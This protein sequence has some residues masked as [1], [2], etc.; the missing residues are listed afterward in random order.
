MTFI[1]KLK[2][3]GLRIL[4]FA[5]A[6][7]RRKKLTLVDKANVLETSRLWR[8]TTQ[9]IAINYPDVKVD[10]MHVDNIAMQL[11]I[12]PKQ[13]DVILTENMFGDILSGEASVL[14]RIFGIV[15]FLLYR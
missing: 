14:N 8:K 4:A 5:A 9:G 13:F 3:N 2:L 15:A 10:Y 11:I 1:I 6:Q 12:N 7:K